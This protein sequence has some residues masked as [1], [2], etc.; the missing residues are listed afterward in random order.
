MDQKVI[1]DLDFQV[2][3][4]TDALN[5]IDAKLLVLDSGRQVINEAL[6]GVQNGTV[7]VNF[8]TKTSK[9]TKKNSYEVIDTGF[10]LAQCSTSESVLDSV[11]LIDNWKKCVGCDI[12]LPL[13]I[14]RAE[15]INSEKINDL[16]S[17][18]QLLLTKVTTGRKIKVNGEEVQ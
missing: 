1:D 15:S 4:S 9:G 2:K 14:D 16:G 7:R 11:V 3:E 13:F 8:Q 18:H 10:T 17:S 12:S 6:E 5:E